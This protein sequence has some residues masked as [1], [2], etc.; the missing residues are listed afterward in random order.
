MEDEK[1]KIKNHEIKKTKENEIKFKILK[2]M[3]NL[4]RIKNN[5]N[6]GD[7]SWAMKQK[8]TKMT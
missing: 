6:G 2:K 8:E 3:I 7:Y 1:G 4:R 5:K